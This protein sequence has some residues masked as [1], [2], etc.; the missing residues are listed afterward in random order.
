VPLRPDICGVKQRV[1]LVGRTSPHAGTSGPEVLAR[2][3]AGIQD[4]TISQ[5]WMAWLRFSRRFRR[6]S[7]HNQILILSQRPTA[8]RVAG[9]RAW[10]EMGRQVRRG[11]RGIAILAPIRISDNQGRSEEDEQELAVGFRVVRVFDLEQTEGPEPPRPLDDL[12]DLTPGFELSRLLEQAAD[13]GFSVEFA[14]LSGERH[15]DCSHALRRIRLRQG[16][17]SAQTLKTAAHELAHAI[18]HGP[19]FGGDRA[20]AELEA[21]SVAYV[22]CDGVGIDSSAYSFGYLA[23]WAGGGEAAVSMISSSGARITRAAG[24][25]LEGAGCPRPR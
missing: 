8:V 6:Y 2:L 3:Q 4:L 19:A 10:Q 14:D 15:G 7:F 11:E 18:M 23:S 24:D 1:A 17:G 22:V 5:R 16:M 12:G 9:Y 21:E 25:I 13:L 20:L